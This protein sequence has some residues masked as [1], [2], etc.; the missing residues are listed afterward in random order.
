MR[1]A[2]EQRVHARLQ[3]G[4]LS[5]PFKALLFEERTLNIRLQY[6]LLRRLT[7][8]V[9]NPGDVA[10]LSE[11]RLIGRIDLKRS[12][13]EHPIRECSARKCSEPQSQCIEIVT[14][15][16]G[17]RSNDLLACIERSPPGQGL[18]YLN[19]AGCSHRAPERAR[20]SGDA[21]RGI[22]ECTGRLDLR[23]G[24]R[25]G[26]PHRLEACVTSEHSLGESLCGQ[27]RW[28]GRGIVSGLLRP[29]RQSDEQRQAGEGG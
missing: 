12:V 19:I 14:C 26:L 21:E 8:R 15:G 28:Q 9:A 4:A 16:L 23:N 29:R 24:G 25:H 10:Q 18:T 1:R 2:V 22:L 3:C 13:D 11:H 20:R 7:C 5:F 6:I 17:R 27:R